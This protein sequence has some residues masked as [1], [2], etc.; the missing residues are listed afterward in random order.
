MVRVVRGGGRWR[1][2]LI[3]RRES[4]KSCKKFRKGNTKKDRGDERRGKSV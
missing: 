2:K 4:N 1:G 3:G